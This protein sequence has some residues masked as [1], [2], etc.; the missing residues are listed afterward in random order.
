M[1][2]KIVLPPAKPAHVDPNVG[3]YFFHDFSRLKLKKDHENR[4]IWVCPNKRIFL[5]TFSPIYK[6]AY[7]FL[8][9]ISDPV[10]RPRNIHEYKIT[11]YSLYAA[12]SLGLRTEDILSGL[13]RMSK[14]ELDPKLCTYITDITGKAGKIRMLLHKNRYFLESLNP[15]MLNALLRNEVV[16]GARKLNAGT[17]F[18]EEGL[19][20]TKIH[21]QGTK[22]GGTSAREAMGMKDLDEKEKKADQ[23]IYKFEILPE[24]VESVRKECRDAGFPMLE[25]Y[26]FRN[27]HLTPNLDIN[28][29]PFAQIRSYQEK[30]L[31]KMFGNGRARSG[32]IVLPCGAGKTLVGITAAQT[33]AKSTLVFC[34]TSVAVDQWRRQFLH[35][36]SVSKR[37]VYM[38]TAEH[39]QRWD[40]K[41]ACV[42]ITSYHMVGHAGKRNPQA[43]AIMDLIRTQE[44]GL[45]LLD[46]VHVAPA[47]SFRKCVGVTHSRCKL[48]LTATLVRE[49]KLID[50]L[51][52]LI[53]PKLYEANWLDLQ[54]QGYI[55][56]V[57]CIEIGCEMT[58]EFYQAYLRANAHKQRLL[59]WM[60]PN[61]FKACEFLIRYHENRGDKVL[62]FSDCRFALEKYAI[63]QGRNYLHGGTETSE[64][65]TLLDKFQSDDKM[66]TL[67]ISK[68]GDNSID[69]PDVNVIIQ[70]SSHF[71]ARRQEAQRLGRILRPKKVSS[72]RFNAFFYTLVSKDTK[73]VFYA[74]KRQ[75]FLVDQGYSFKVIPSVDQ[76]LKSGHKV[77]RNIKFS[78]KKEQLELLSQVLSVEDTRA[79]AEESEVADGTNLNRKRKGGQGGSR[80]GGRGRVVR[81]QG[82]ASD[83]SGAAGLSYGGGQARK[84]KKPE[85]SR[86][87][88]KRDEERKA[89]RRGY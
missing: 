36:T 2:F 80:W 54:E 35:W 83:L 59:Y 15:D 1:S 88:V 74:T 57:K 6:Q 25:E 31:S 62:V 79:V 58:P 21:L 52:Y 24:K 30:S 39:R 10:T 43:E 20:T 12:A 53:G 61:K 72:T 77:S 7:D 64:R 18:I 28:L 67:F 55:A 76:L 78:S 29:K 13:R 47:K 81:R 44:W 16:R 84:K 60:N 23:K 63:T 48:G 14:N 9:A 40:T 45:I 38:F 70:I 82:N 19:K 86:L 46:E 56:T 68:V 41:Q 50:D 34:T 3:D 71:A 75:R 8:I 73:E 49:D 22:D 27:D 4:P 11:S 32:I 33:V 37:K 66:N 65:L 85:R 5:E 26:D 69:L 51:Y 87:F 42:V 17:G 89:R